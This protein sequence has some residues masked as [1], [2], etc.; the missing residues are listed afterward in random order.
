MNDRSFKIKMALAA[1]VAIWAFVSLMPIT[2]RPFEVFIRTRAKANRE[3]FQSLLD[4]AQK[5]VDE[6]SSRTVFLALLEMGESEQI[7]YA[8]FFPD[9]K[10]ADIKNLKKRNKILMHAL[11]KEPQSVFKQGLDLKGGVSFTLQISPTALKDKDDWACRQLVQKAIGIIESRI[12]ALG[13]A[14][15]IIRPK[16]RGYIEVQ[17]PGLSVQDNPDIVNAL[18][19]PAKLEFKL[20]RTDVDPGGQLP[21]GFERLVMEHENNQTGFIDEIPV[22]IKKIPEMTGKMVKNA[23]PVINPYGS[24]EVSLQMTQEGSRCFADITRKN[25]H[26]PLAIVLDGKVYSTPVIQSEITTGQASISGSFSQREAFELSN[27]LNNPLEFELDLVEMCEIGPSLAQDARHVAY[28]GAWVGIFLIMIVLIYYYRSPGLIAAATLF[29]NFLL[30]LGSWAALGATITLPSIT[31][32]ALTFSMAV[33]A[34]ILIFER[35]REEM[36]NGKDVVVATFLGHHRAFT[37]ILDSNLTTLIAAL[38]LIGFGTGSVKGFGVTLAVGI[39]TSMFS[40]L[41]F[42]R[43]IL[44]WLVELKVVGF[45]ASSFWAKTNFDFLKIRRIAFCFAGL[46]IAFAV[47]VFVWKGKRMYS[48]DFVG[49]DEMVLRYTS[50]IGHKDVNRL[51]KL[52]NLGNINCVYQ[53]YIGE[54]KIV[55]LLKIQTERDRSG[56]VL[57]TLQKCFP[58]AQLELVSQNTIGGSVSGEVQRSALLAAGLAMIGMLIYIALRFEFGYGIGAVLALLHDVVITSGLYVFFG[59]QFSA[60]MVAAVMMVIGY[61]I[62]DTIVV[63]DRIREELSLNPFATLYDVVNLSINKTLSRTILTSLMIFVP[64]GVMFIYCSGVVS[65]YSLVSMLGIVVGTFSS[66]FV[67]SPIFYLWHKGKR[68]SVEAHHDTLPVRDWTK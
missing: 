34:N 44:E 25:L 22:V 63:F 68:R 15:P 57:R 18:K 46:M 24:Y 16:G 14:E 31:A 56:T 32:L 7:D 5:R 20:V 42:N 48:I 10:L 61:S 30:I 28:Q 43:A 54:K 12:D 17:L 49:G 67:A 11:A 40:I 66:I 13:V 37:T 21:L 8:R 65:D 39:F 23:S 26:R 45:K 41:V 27:V 59:R 38:L 9:I 64:A 60:P 51:A 50:A 53:R 52:E 3:E 4:R 19:K 29:F 1:A 62:N 2:E 47:A 6:G 35:A 33:D 55:N 36:R 58:S